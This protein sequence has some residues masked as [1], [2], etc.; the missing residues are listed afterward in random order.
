M[1]HLRELSEGLSHIYWLGGSPCAGKSSI[2]QLLARRHGLQVYSPDDHYL[3][4]LDRADPLLQPNVYGAKGKSWDEIWS[5]PV[6]KAVSDEF[7]FYRQEFG[8]ILDDLLA[9][10][11][12]RPV[13][14]E[15][16]SLLPECVA[17]LLLSTR[18]G[19]WVVP[20]PAFQ[21]HHYSQRPWIQGILS[22]CRDPK[23]AF[24]TWMGRDIEFARLVALDTR[25]RGLEVVV[26]DGSRDL[27]E[28]ASLAE[29][30]FELTA[31]K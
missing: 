17:P 1:N 16:A 13:I 27:D 12:D 26:V 6:D 25:N 7:A 30:H 9:L 21:L 18:R 19:L 4:H 20:T 28:V 14:A 5:R 2:A 3:E 11:R 31:P 8:M 15:G 29:A 10:P 22:Q 24:D 23:T